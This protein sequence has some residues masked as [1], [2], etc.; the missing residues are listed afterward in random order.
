MSWH[1]QWRGGQLQLAGEQLCQPVTSLAN[2]QWLV[3][4]PAF[5]LQ[6]AE[7][8]YQC[9]F[10]L[11]TLDW[12]AEA[13]L[14]ATTD[15][16][17]RLSFCPGIMSRNFYLQSLQN[18]VGAM[19]PSA[20]SLVELAGEHYALALVLRVHAQDVDLMLLSALA[21]ITGKQLLPGQVFNC[22]FDRLQPYRPN[23]LQ[24]RLSA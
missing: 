22:R 2:S 15:A 11:E 6:Q 9:W 4:E 20:F 3:D 5:T 7:W 1:W 13:L 21:T 24:P 8:F 23:K 12:P 10:A 14:A 19:Q 16:V 18:S 17:A